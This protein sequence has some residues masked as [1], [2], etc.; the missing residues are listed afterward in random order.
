MYTQPVYLQ[1]LLDFQSVLVHLVVQRDL[2]LLVLLL[3][4]VDHS[5]LCYPNAKM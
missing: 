4:L 5:L 3:L 1:L 2:M